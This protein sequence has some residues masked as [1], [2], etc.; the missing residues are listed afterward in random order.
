MKRLALHKLVLFPQLRL[1]KANQRRI[2]AMG[3]FP[4]VSG[5]EVD[6]KGLT[7]GLDLLS[8]NRVEMALRISLGNN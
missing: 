1:I 2:E 5:S 3:I 7:G 4:Q 6:L 8:G